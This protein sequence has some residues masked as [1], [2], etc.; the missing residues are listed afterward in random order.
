M[1]EGKAAYEDGDPSEDGIEEIEGPHRSDADEVEERT[2]HAQVG[3]RLVQAFEDSI[4]AMLLLRFVWHTLLLYWGVEVVLYAPEPTQDVH[5][6]DGNAGSC[7]NTS[8][9]LLRTGFPVG[10]AV[11]AD[12]DCYQTCNFRDRPGEKA[13]DSVKAGIEW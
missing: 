8:Q 12:H 11:A 9:R 3:E 13:L 1:A 6:Q 4:C 10:E 7:G 2:L 5:S